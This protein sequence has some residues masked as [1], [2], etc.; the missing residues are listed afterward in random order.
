MPL[1][2]AAFTLAL[3]ARRPRAWYCRRSECPT[4]DVAAAELGQHRAGDLAGVGAGV[5]RRESCAPYLMLQLVAVDQGLHRAQVGE[6]RQH[7]DLDR[8]SKSLSVSANASF[9]T[10]AMA[11]RWLRFIFQLPAISGRAAASC[12][13]PDFGWAIGASVLQYGEPGR[14]L[15]SRY[16]RLAPPPVEMWPNAVSSKPSVRTAAAESPPP[17][18]VKRRRPRSAPGRP[19]GCR[20]RT[21]SNSNTPIGPFQNTVLASASLRREQLARTPG[22]CPGPAGRPGSR[23][24]RRPSCVGVRRRSRWPPPCRPGARTPRRAWPPRRGSRAPCRSG[25]PGAGDLPTS[26]PWALRKV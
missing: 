5:V 26:W 22:R 1:R 13:R 24:R 14:V 20:R 3:T 19:R 18:T 2:K 15:P 16:S 6:R 17:T 12:R 25:P 8:A 11:S 9:W 4:S 7:R 23:R 21:A 10:W